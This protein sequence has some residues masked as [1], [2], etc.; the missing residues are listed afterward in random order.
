MQR[1]HFDRF[2][3]ELFR[4]LFN[5]FN[6]QVNRAVGRQN[7][8]RNFGINLF[9]TRKQVQ[10]RAIRQHVISDDY[11]RSRIA[12]KV[13][14]ILAGLRFFDFVAL[15]L[16]KVTDTETNCGLIIDDQDPIFSHQL[17]PRLAVGI[18]R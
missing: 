8:Q 10:R 9:Q 4:S 16:K 6:C 11:I 1:R 12:E 17:S 7:Q 5:G 2:G 15:K 3:E 13:T 18:A 14:R